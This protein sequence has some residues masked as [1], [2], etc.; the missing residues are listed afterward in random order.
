MDFFH[1]RDKQAL[2]SNGCCFTK[3]CS[4]INHRVE[5][6]CRRVVCFML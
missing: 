4:A 5:K 3:R 6:S 2:W 1:P